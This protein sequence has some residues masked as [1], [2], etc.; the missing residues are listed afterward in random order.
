MGVIFIVNLE[1]GYLTPPIGI[2]LFVASAAFKKPMGAV[3]KSVVPFIGLMFVGLMIVTYV[4]SVAVGPVNVLL[5]DK[6]FYEPFPEAKAGCGGRRC[7]RT[8]W[9]RLLTRASHAK[10]PTE[11]GQAAHGGAR[12]A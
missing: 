6:P 10:L 2:N 8:I 7:H 12:S 1:I 9:R 11:E 5:R 3:I 4:P